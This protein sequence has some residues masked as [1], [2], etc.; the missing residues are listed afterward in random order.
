MYVST[1]PLDV[2]ARSGLA[3]FAKYWPGNIVVVA[4]P[5]QAPG[6]AAGAR[7]PVELITTA[8]PV[9]DVARAKPDVILTLL[10]LDSA[11]YLKIAPVVYIVETDRRIRSQIQ[12]ANEASQVI[13]MR[14]RAGQYRSERAYRSLVD[15]AA[16][17]Q[18]NGPQAWISYSRLSRNPI[19]FQDHRISRRDLAAAASRRYWTGDRPLR[20]AF[21]GRLIPIKG[22]NRVLE[23]ARHLP[24]AEFEIVGDGPLR[25]SL[26][27]NAP[28]NVS[29]S[30]YIPF[31]SWPIHMRRKVDLALLPHPQ[32]DPS[33]TYFESLGCGVPVIGTRN[34]TWKFYAYHGIGW[35]AD[36]PLDMARIILSLTPA[37]LASAGKR[38]MAIVK[39]F[40]EVARARM[41]HVLE[42]AITEHIYHPQTGD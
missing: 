3:M 41:R 16:G 38:G 34:P 33:C 12:L 39:P 2:K 24:D 42:C 28:R 14:I 20:I 21:S 15:R 26:E 5:P 9:S 25:A 7:L 18:C 6:T 36:S 8:D 1:G 37:A 11:A 23:V 19:F 4:P 22:P 30:G 10:R 35:A 27:K 32:G 13:R 31:E 40:D 29:F 17:I